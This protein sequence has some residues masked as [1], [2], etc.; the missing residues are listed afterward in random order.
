MPD[1]HRVCMSL[2]L[3]DDQ[4]II[5]KY[6]KYHQPGNVWQEV[7]DGLKL[8]GIINMEIY[9]VGDQL[10]FIIDMKKN[11]TLEDKQKIDKEDPMIQEWEALMS[12]FFSDNRLAKNG[13]NRVLMNKIFCLSEH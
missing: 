13:E 8:S 10:F 9:H 11:F 7:I 2:N 12:Q 1:T 5:N 6:I 4:E 3:I